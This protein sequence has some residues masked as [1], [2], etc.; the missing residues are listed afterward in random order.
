M[1]FLRKIYR[2]LGSPGSNYFARIP[3]IIRRPMSWILLLIVLFSVAAIVSGAVAVIMA[4]AI[5][6]PDRMTDGR[7]VAI[8]HRLSPEDLDLPYANLN[9]D[10]RDEQTGDRMRIVG[11]WIPSAVPSNRT[12]LIL[13]GHSDAKVGGIA[14]APLFHEMGFN[15]CVIDLRA[16]GESG[17]KYTTAGYYERYDTAQ[18]IDQLHRDKP[19]AM[20]KLTLFGVSHGGAIAIATAC[21]RDDIAAVI[22]DS[23]YRDF[24]SAARHQAEAVGTPLRFT[25]GFATRL[26]EWFASADFDEVAPAQLIPTLRTPIFMISSGN[27]PMVPPDDLRALQT[28]LQSRPA[29]FGLGDSWLIPNAYHVCGLQEEPEMYRARVKTFLSAV[30]AI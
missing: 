28:A 5:V 6:E 25:F 22:V 23:P 16:H 9:F 20:K 30:S 21:Q 7:A 4:R 8:F 3:A 14:W 27:D 19:A 17:G 11:W 18:V 29:D 12:C 26:A 24:A 2:T 15:V 13:H 10:V 1:H